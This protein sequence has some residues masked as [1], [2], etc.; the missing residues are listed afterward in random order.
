MRWQQRWDFTLHRRRRGR[1]R[2]GRLW[3]WLAGFTGFTRGGKGVLDDRCG[4]RQPARARPW[5]RPLPAV[6]GG[7]PVTAVALDVVGGVLEPA[8]ATRR[9]IP[10]VAIAVR[11]AKNARAAT[12]HE[13][14]PRKRVAAG[15]RN[16]RKGVENK[17]ANTK[18]MPHWNTL[19]CRPVPVEKQRLVLDRVRARVPARPLRHHAGRVAALTGSRRCRPTTC[20]KQRC[21]PRPTTARSTARRHRAS[22]APFTSSACRTGCPASRRRRCRRSRRRGS[23]SCRLGRWRTTV[24]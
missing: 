3:P 13:K 21:R 4:I 8:A 19:A 17:S 9:T 24:G 16:N 22:A 23:C 20:G 1:L 6:A 12:A 14:N 2:H 11:H 5:R 18:T 10:L 15:R 7:V